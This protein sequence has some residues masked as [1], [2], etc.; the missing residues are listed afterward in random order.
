MKRI[1]DDVIKKYPNA[2]VEYFTSDEESRL[3]SW[4][5]EQAG[6]PGSNADAVAVIGHSWGGDTAATVVAHGRKVGSLITIDPV[7]EFSPDLN[8]VRENSTVWIN[9]NGNPTKEK[10]EEPG[11][12]GNFWADTFGKWKGDPD[13]IAHHHYNA[14]VNHGEIRELIIN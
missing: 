14:N 7:S 5:E 8:K 6:L 11:L 10:R 2:N 3:K 1:N 13:G 4:L 12:H 9:V